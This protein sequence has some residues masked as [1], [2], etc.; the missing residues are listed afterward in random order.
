MPDMQSPGMLHRRRLPFTAIVA[1]WRTLVAYVC[2]PYRPEL[3]YMRG[4]GPRWHARQGGAR[5]VGC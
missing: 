3:H 1:S 4:P 2:D 5:R